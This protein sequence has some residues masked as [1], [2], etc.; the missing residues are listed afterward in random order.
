MA[1]GFNNET[2]R[3][4]L[5]SEYIDGDIIEVRELRAGF[6]GVVYTATVAC[7]DPKT[8]SVD[9]YNRFFDIG[10]DYIFDI[11]TK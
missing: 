1:I 2:E 6:G 9:E 11:V 8:T 4:V 10:L 5:K 7:F 3:L